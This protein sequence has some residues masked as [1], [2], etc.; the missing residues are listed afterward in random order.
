MDRKNDWPKLTFAW[1]KLE[2]F[3]KNVNKFQHSFP[4]LKKE[5]SFRLP[6]TF[7]WMNYERYSIEVVNVYFFIGIYTWRQRLARESLASAKQKC[8]AAAAAPSP[9][10]SQFRFKKYFA[11]ERNLAK[12]K[13]FRFVSPQFQE[14]K[15]QK[16][17]F[18]SL[19]CA[20]QVSHCFAKEQ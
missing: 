17:R 6:S 1:L 7:I 20:S 8:A 4:G 5:H 16:F 13:Q 3:A 2:K 11:S 14:T 15:K 9:R 19:R 12:Q 10:V 18:I